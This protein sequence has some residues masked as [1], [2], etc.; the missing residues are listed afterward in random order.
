MKKKPTK[1]K[2]YVELTAAWG[3]DDADST[4]NASRRL[5]KKFKMVPSMSPL[6]GRGMRVGGAPFAGIFRTRKFQ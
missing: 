2:I 6:R 4:I 3:N 1:P 5:W